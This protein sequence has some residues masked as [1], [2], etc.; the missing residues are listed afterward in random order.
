MTA[1]IALSLKQ[2]LVRNGSRAVYVKQV[3]QKSGDT[4]GSSRFNK[5]K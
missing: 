2:C 5:V 4:V 1:F 3:M